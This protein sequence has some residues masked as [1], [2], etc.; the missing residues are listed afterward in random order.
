MSTTSTNDPAAATTSSGYLLP[1]VLAAGLVLTFF[2][3]LSTG[4]ILAVGVL[5]VVFAMVGFLLN[6]YGF[7]TADV[8]SPLLATPSPQPVGSATSS[9][10]NVNLVGSEVFH[11]SDNS[12][13]YDDAPA[14]CAAYDS[15]LASLEQIIDAYN[16][17]A[18]WCGYGWSAGGM[19][20]YPTQK[21][22]WDALQQEVDQGKKTACGR[23]G[24]NGGYFDP[25]SKFGVN[26]Y[27]IKPQGTIKLPTPL[28]GTDQSAFN[29]AVAKFKSMIKSFN[30]DPYSRSTWSGSGTAP[31]SG[32]LSAGKQFIQ[33]VTT[34][35][36]SMGSIPDMEVM[37]GQ[38]L[39]NTGL[40]LG[41]P[42]GLRGEQGDL[43]PA[44]PM[45]P[46][47]AAST[48]PGPG[49]P[50]GPAGQNGSPGAA[51]TVAGPAGPK[52]DTGAL[53]AAG[54]SRIDQI[55]SAAA[56]ANST[57]NAAKTAASTA[58]QPTALDAVKTTATNAA[59]AAAA[60][61]TAAT[62]AQTAAAAPRPAGPVHL[63][64]RWVI[65]EEA[66]NQALVFRDT[67]APDKRYAMWANTSRD[68]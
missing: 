5:W 40:P 26:C 4:S 35:H 28:P 63:G 50:T 56:V 7:I 42:Y 66:G 51:S 60:A 43:G 57:A 31:A 1:A 67:L 55:A 16:H 13:T 9:L 20:L 36:F 27:G 6:V 2:V 49:G 8:L 22:T 30:L 46:A 12:F 62:A 25:T 15:Q 68:L 34:E 45:G 14:V 32:A 23:P 48:V 58:V 44:G 19:A 61:Q 17:G 11:I 38:T 54:S 39:A 18:E 47:G 29:S 37:P 10:T 52:G 33:G 59:S 21:S 3:L 41:S 64:S 53:D 65:E 24:V